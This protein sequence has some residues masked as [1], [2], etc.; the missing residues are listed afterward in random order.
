MVRRMNW[1]N[2]RSLYRRKCNA[3]GHEEEIV[4][5][6]SPEKS[7]TIYDQ[8]YWWSDLWNS[9]AYGQEYDFSKPFFLQF[10]KLLEKMPL[11]AVFNGNAVNSEYANHALD[12]KNSYL[13]TAAWHN[14]N[15]LYSNRTL[16]NRD[17]LDLYL[18]DRNELCYEN[19]N[20]GPSSGFILVMAVRIAVI[21]LFF[22]I[23]GIVQIVLAVLDCAISHI[24]FLISR[25]RRKSI[26]TRLR[27]L[28]LEVIVCF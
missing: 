12:S 14:E 18:T 26:T 13:I 4:S 22:T 11:L 5:A 6:F 2:E 9:S 1:R 23:A 10:C 27:R 28:T 17:S 7:F 16:N 25:I 19:V 8:K 15:V 21:P 24:I 3:P 20:C